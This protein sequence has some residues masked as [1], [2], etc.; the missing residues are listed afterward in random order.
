MGSQAQL[1]LIMNPEYSRQIWSQKPEQAPN[2]LDN[3]DPS[4]KHS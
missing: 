2:M 4:G 1:S 3:P